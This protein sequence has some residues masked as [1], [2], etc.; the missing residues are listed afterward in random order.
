MVTARIA[1]ATARGI[2]L[3]YNQSSLCKFGGHVGVNRS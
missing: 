3:S 1:M 2:P